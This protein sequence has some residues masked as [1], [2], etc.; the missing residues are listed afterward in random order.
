M[1]NR[2]AIVTQWVDEHTEYMLRWATARLP[3]EGHARDAVQDT[4]LAALQSVSSFEYRSSVRTWL[5]S[6]LNNKIADYYRKQAREPL[7]G[8]DYNNEDHFFDKSGN[9]QMDKHPGQWAEDEHLLDNSVFRSVLQSCL[10]KLPNQWSAALRMKY[11][12]ERKGEDICKDLDVSQA[13]YWQIVRRAKLSLR[14]CLELNWF[15]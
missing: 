7:A 12:S 1:D 6:I 15:K 14:E 3:D 4:F 9:W 10:S 2:E 5:V 8:T 13:N 11:L